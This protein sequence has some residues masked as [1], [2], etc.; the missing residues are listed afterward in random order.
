MGKKVVA[1]QQEEQMTILSSMEKIVDMAEDS[2][3]SEKF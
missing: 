3:L 1:K 2:R